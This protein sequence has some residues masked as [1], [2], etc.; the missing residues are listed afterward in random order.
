MRAGVCEVEDDLL[1]EGLLVS[2]GFEVGYGV[3]LGGM[4]ASQGPRVITVAGGVTLCS[5]VKVVVLGSFA[6]TVTGHHG[7]ALSGKSLMVM[8]EVTVEV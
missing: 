5:G 6:P 8:V 1:E 7:I 3:T 4:G 2:E